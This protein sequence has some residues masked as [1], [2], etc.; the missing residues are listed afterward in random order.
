MRVGE[1][2]VEVVAEGRSD[3]RRGDASVKRRRTTVD[4]LA[5]PTSQRVVSGGL[6]SAL[7][8]VHRIACAVNDVV[9]DAVLDERRTRSASRTAAAML[10]SFS[11]NSNSGAPSQYSY[12][13]RRTRVVELDRV[14]SAADSA[15][16][17]RARR[18]VVVP[19][20]RCCETRSSAAGAAA[21]ARVRGWSTVIR[22]RM[23]SATPSRTRRR[24]RSSGCR[25]RR[26][27]RSVR[28]R[29]RACRGGGS[30]RPAVP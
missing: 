11:V 26:R 28:I 13:V 9:V 1:D 8:R 14:R 29:A 22:T 17:L 7:R 5:R 23:S 19:T 18:I 27:C 20:T 4:G 6:G 2:R 10:V 30:L 3:L 24:R 16:E 25:R 15:C 12:G 21:R